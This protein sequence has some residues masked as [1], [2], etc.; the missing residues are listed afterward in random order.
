MRE[1]AE[2][3]FTIAAE[4]PPV[5]GCT[6]TALVKS[7]DE[8]DVYHFSLA[9]RTNISAES[10]S[11]PKL[12]IVD[13]GSLELFT[14][15]GAV[16]LHAGEA[17]VAPINIPV[18]VRTESG[19]V[20]TEIALKQEA[21]MNEIMKAGEVFALKDLVPYQEGRIVN[22]DLIDSPKL[23]FEVMSFASGTGLSEHAAPGEALVFALDGQA[24]IGYEGKDY[25]IRAG[26]NFKIAKNGRHSVRA[27]GPFKMALLLTLE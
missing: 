6:V 5:P 9:E 15:A 10:Y 16:T 21:V 26:E 8:Y 13:S 27:D 12:I 7:V 24:V 25:P 14:A 18:G 3:A 4:N 2:G 20:Y 1:S 11:Y 19:C 17:A 23:K 22:L